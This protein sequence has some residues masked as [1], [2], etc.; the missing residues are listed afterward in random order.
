MLSFGSPLSSKLSLAFPPVVIETV[1]V[2]S[3]NVEV[4]PDL[5]TDRFN[6][7]AKGLLVKLSY[8]N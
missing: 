2:F 6:Y 3:S 4:R 5:I 8:L 7:I 1:S